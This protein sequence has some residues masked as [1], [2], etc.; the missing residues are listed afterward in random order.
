[1]VTARSTPAQPPTSPSTRSQPSHHAAEIPPADT[2]SAPRRRFGEEA[3]RDAA[4]RGLTWSERRYLGQLFDLLEWGV[5]LRIR[6]T[7]TRLESNSMETR[8]QADRG[9]PALL[10]N[11]NQLAPPHGLKVMHR[12]LIDALTLHRDF[13]DAWDAS[14][15]TPDIPRSPLVRDASNKL[16]AVTEALISSFPGVSSHNRRA[17]FDHLSAVDFV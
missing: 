2:R 17:F 7:R 12:R 9:Y 1:M 3:D 6:S 11:L 14:E 8:M 13:F 5:A 4:D 16:R 15:D 10:A